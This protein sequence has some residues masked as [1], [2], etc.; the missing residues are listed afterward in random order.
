M[1][2]VSALSQRKRAE[3]EREREL[4]NS[5]MFLILFHVKKVKSGLIYMIHVPILRGWV[6]RLKLVKMSQIIMSYLR[7]VGRWSL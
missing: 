6:G 1:I 4:D 5:V 7:K 3:R 2:I